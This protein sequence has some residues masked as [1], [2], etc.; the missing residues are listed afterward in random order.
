M[1]NEQLEKLIDLALADGEL[2]EKEKQVLFKKAETLGIDLDEF[3][4]VLDAK[5]FEKQKLFQIQT[6]QTNQ[7][8][9]P[10]SDKYG[11]IKKCPS[12][13]AIVQ[14]FSAVCDDCS[15]AFR[16]V[17][18]DVSINKLFDLLMEA[19]NIPKD[20]F[21]EVNQFGGGLLG[22]L[23]GASDIMGQER[24][25]DEYNKNHQQKIQARKVQIISNFP[26]PNS[27]ESVLEFLTLGVSKAVK[28]KKGFFSSK[29]TVAEEEHN[30]LAPVWKAKIDQ[31]AMKARMSSK[32]D[33]S[34]LSDIE[35][36]FS[37]VNSK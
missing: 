17:E 36:L 12:C 31:V 13:G 11:E 37:K 3:E 9:A 23:M 1:Y 24:R 27:K 35:S 16:N 6:P 2:T 28:I 5:L 26:V 29:I 34:F 4:M 8:A 33:S 19:D 7:S 18:S 30:A 22:T 32:G 14:S 20:K 15:Y 21:R 25:I 10:S